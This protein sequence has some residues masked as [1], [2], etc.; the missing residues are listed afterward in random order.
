MG[1]AG[2]PAPWSSQGPPGRFQASQC[3]PAAA[4]L[5][6]RTGGDH[7]R[8][9]GQSEEGAPCSAEGN[10]EEEWNAVWILH[11]RHGGWLFMK[12]F[13]F[14]FF[15]FLRWGGGIARSFEGMGRNV[16]CTAELV[17]VL[18]GFSMSVSCFSWGDGIAAFR[19]YAF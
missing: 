7:S 13:D 16:G 2:E 1:G 12:G 19:G 17:G 14:G 10:C 9:A 5:H 6:E 3:V 4:V 8:G 15:V 11:A 18:M